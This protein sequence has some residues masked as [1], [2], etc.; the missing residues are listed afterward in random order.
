MESFNPGIGLNRMYNTVFDMNKVAAIQEEALRIYPEDKQDDGKDRNEDRRLYYEMQQYAVLYFNKF[1]PHDDM[2]DEFFHDLKFLG[3]FIHCYSKVEDDKL[4]DK[5]G[6]LID[7][8]YDKN[9]NPIKEL[10]DKNGNSITKVSSDSKL[11]FI[12]ISFE[13][14]IVVH[15]L[16]VP[17][18][19]YNQNFSFGKENDMS[20]IQNRID[21]NF[22]L[23]HFRFDNDIKLITLYTEKTSVIRK[24]IA[25]GQVDKKDFGCTI[26][27]NRF[28]KLP[29]YDLV[30]HCFIRKE[31]EIKRL[32]N[33]PKDF[34][35]PDTSVA[36]F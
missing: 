20:S 15:H 34:K 30:N 32:K 18:K 24:W 35:K 19:G 8:I 2:R 23:G 29:P 9:G 28:R 31:D 12:Y 4:F 26:D 6:K 33:L 21:V 11:R 3:R 27:C 5:T 14:G 16:S 17:G 10:C 36:L 25:D 13:N 7:G 22:F 1:F